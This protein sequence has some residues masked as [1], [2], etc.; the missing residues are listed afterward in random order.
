MPPGPTP[1]PFIGNILQVKP[2]DMLK[3]FR[4][5]H[6]KY[7]PVYVIYFRNVPI[8]VLNGC[9]AVKEAL[10]DNADVF[11]A[12]ATPLGF[13][14]F[15]SEYGIISSN[16]ERWKQL[17]RFALMTMRNFGM[18]KR[19]IEERIQEEAQ[20]LVEELQ[21]T[22]GSPFD[23]TFYISRSISNIICSI[24]FGYRFDYQDEKFLKLLKL[25]NEFSKLLDSP[26]S[27]IFNLFPHI[28][29]YIP[30]PHLRVIENMTCL[31]E[32]II[33]KKKVHERSLDPNC[34]RDFIDCFLIKMEK[35]KQNPASEFN[36]DNLVMS[37]L[38]LF[39]AGTETTSTT[40][41]YAFLI[42]LK[43]PEIKENVV[44]EI[45][46]VIGQDRAPAVEDRSKMPYTDAV[47]HEV[48]R[49]ADIV[50]LGVPHVVTQDI[51]F[52]GYTIPKETMVITALTTVLK[53]P[54]WFKNPDSF[55]PGHFLDENG[56][57]KKNDAFMP[58]SAGK[59]ICLGEGL[60][61]MELFLIFTTILQNFTLTTTKDP[62]DIDLSSGLRTGSA[63]RPY[64]LC[65]RP[66]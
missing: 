39:F 6:K 41:R 20:F 48:Q 38:N 32:F 57:F 5:L 52:R 45:D 2:N 60:A 54:K 26:F 15:F 62:K 61:R 56:A 10:I 11:G 43:N 47:I 18:G 35:E 19:S 14:K 21:K 49:F 13:T 65:V 29:Q 16:G 3:S 25:L 58:F 44:R 42:L 34:P 23:P 46:L 36:D 64:L 22:K 50:P 37:T 33:E 40:L 66:R 53:D 30:G 31:K 12:R 9:D 24:V 28:M 55:D 4:K 59:R 1:L 63:P 17:R 7:G 51:E 8:L 27:Q